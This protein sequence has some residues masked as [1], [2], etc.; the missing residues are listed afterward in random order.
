MNAVAKNYYEQVLLVTQEFLGPAAE[1]FINRQ[2][3][4]HLDKPPEVITKDDVFTLRD[5]VKVA[6]G[7]L[8]NDQTVVK[9][10]VDR[11]NSIVKK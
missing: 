1:R 9:Q 2:I 6:L 10:V 8:I 5:S 7:L 4:F 3:E 11:F